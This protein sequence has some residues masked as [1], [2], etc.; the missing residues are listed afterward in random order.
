MEFSGV[1]NGMIL[2][3][4]CALAISVVAIQAI[5]FIR[6]AWRRG[7]EVGLTKRVMQ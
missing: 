2:F 7:G 4:L 5:I 3:I 6:I 1:A